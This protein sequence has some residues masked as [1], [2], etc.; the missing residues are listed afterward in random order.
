VLEGSTLGGQYILRELEKR[1]ITTETGAAFFACYGARTAE[2][3]KSFKETAN[4]YCAHEPR[5]AEAEA[6]ARATFARYRRGVSPL[7]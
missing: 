6:A 7:E 5:A 3:W 2:M 1:G 4:A